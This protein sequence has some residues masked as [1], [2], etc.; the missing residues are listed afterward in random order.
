MTVK[1]NVGDG[2]T[3]HWE[4]GVVKLKADEKLAQYLAYLLPAYINGERSS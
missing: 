2:S 3:R 1:G 4:A